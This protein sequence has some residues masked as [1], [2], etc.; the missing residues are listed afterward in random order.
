MKQ[1]QK[2]FTC[3]H[4]NQNVFKELYMWLLIRFDRICALLA[5]C[6]PVAQHLCKC[7]HTNIWS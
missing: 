4:F 6:L 1:I 5:Y 7:L 3:L 2:H